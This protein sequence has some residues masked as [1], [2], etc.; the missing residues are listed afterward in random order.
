MTAPVLSATTRTG[1]QLST[2]WVSPT[3][4]RISA[5]GDIDAAN[6]TDVLDYVLRRAANCRSL[7][8]DFKDV[9]FFATAGFSMLQ[10]IANRSS[11]AS[12][13]WMVVPSAPVARVLT[14]CDP[15]RALPRGLE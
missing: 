10:T 8:L 11:R 12:V 5:S 1:L 3:I 9:T 7:I 4:V 13:S 14:I 15:Q 2:E 6:Y